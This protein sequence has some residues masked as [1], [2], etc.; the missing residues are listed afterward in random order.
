MYLIKRWL[1]RN[2]DSGV[3]GGNKSKNEDRIV[4]YDYFLSKNKGFLF[5]HYLPWL[6]QLGY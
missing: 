2:S 6:I 5:L 1:N 4:L 3:S